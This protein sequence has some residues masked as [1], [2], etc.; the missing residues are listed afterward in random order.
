MLAM[1][2]LK[3]NSQVTSSS[4][5]GTVMD[6]AGNYL[7]GAT[8]TAT[9][10][11]SGT[12]YTT[13][14]RKGGV[15][16]IPSAR[17]G[18]PYTIKVDYVGYKSYQ[19]DGITL[20]LGE[21]YNINAVM[22]EE[23]KD[24]ASVVV[25]VQRRKSAVDKTGASTNVGQRQITSL[26]TISRSIT[27]FTRLTPQA[28]GTSFGGRDARYNNVQVDGANLNNNFGLSSDLLPGGGNQPIS[29]DAIEELSIN[30]APYDVRQAGFT[31]AGVNAVTKSGTN[32][33]KGTAY[34]YYR[35]Q[36]FNGTRVGDTKL[37]EQQKEKT[38]S[39]V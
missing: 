14:S 27:D 1:A 26:P 16:V 36:S 18:G 12:V 35:D 5:T 19:V 21:P 22:G 29:L 30:I 17:I 25:T 31:G 11:P 20:I 38:R 13:L 3:A 37:P 6:S 32:T 33:L 9:H 4:I 10:T 23:F 15:F 34:A 7:E 2:A 39:M 28:N 8:I 24:L